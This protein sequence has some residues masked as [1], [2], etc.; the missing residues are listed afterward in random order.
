[1]KF[2]KSSLSDFFVRIA[3]VCLTV[4]TIALSLHLWKKHRVKK[5]LEN[6]F[7]LHKDYPHD[8]LQQ[9]Y[10]ILTRIKTHEKNTEFSTSISL[11]EFNS[12]LH[13]PLAKA[14]WAES[15]ED[16]QPFWDTKKGLQVTLST[17][18]GTTTLYATELM[19][20]KNGIPQIK[21]KYISGQHLPNN[22]NTI[23]CTLDPSVIGLSLK[24]KTLQ[25]GGS[26]IS[27]TGKN[28]HVSN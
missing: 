16:I 15:I 28:I 26:R 1:M 21:L 25:V 14:S 4:T 13:L 22:K 27:F 23:K 2:S 20:N 17:K 19:I 10:N 8:K 18:K 6:N 9:G 5:V 3:V 11:N 7:S 12:L 24:M